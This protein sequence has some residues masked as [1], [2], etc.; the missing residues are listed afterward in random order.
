[1]N[2]VAG[3]DAGGRPYSWWRLWIC[4]VV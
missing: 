4:S 2:S 1:L 3:R